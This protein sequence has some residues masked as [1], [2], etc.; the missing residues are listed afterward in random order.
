MSDPSPLTDDEREDLVAYL[1]GELDEE[2]AR[3][4]E[5]RINLDPR[6][7]TEAE[8]L[9]SAWDMLDYL[10]RPEASPA[11]THRT[12]ERVTR[13]PATMRVGGG[14]WRALAAAVGW[15]A[16]LLVAALLGYGGG[17]AWLAQYPTDDDLVRDLRILDNKRL[18][19]PV[20]DLEFLKKLA[21]P[22]LFGDDSHDS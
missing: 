18:Y 13:Q 14:R 11:F 21:H 5:A 12:L 20:E 2:K 4:I 6:M 9:R 7:R 15:A 10:P 16:A 19:E 22:D 17:N 8:A 3:A 1:D